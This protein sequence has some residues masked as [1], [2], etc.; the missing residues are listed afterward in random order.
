MIGLPHPGAGWT[1]QKITCAVMSGGRGTRFKAPDSSHKSMFTID[2][3]P[4]L[5]HVVDY[6]RAFTDDFVFVVK[7]GKEELIEYVRTIP[8]RA[9]FVEPAELKGIADGLTYAE[10]HVGERFILVL[11]DCF[12]RGRIAFPPAFQAGVVVQRTKN[13]AALRRN[14]AVHVDGDLVLRLEEKPTVL[15]SDLCGLG[16]YFLPRSV[17]GSIRR[18][19]PSART[20]QVEITDVLGTMVREGVP[21]RSLM[22]DGQYVNV[23]VPEDLDIVRGLLD[24]DQVRACP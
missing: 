4:L 22:L 8:I 23:T 3:Q 1:G 5:R 6:W 19:A 13:E 21:L 14:F 11:G 17:F 20:G 24:L 16:F 18:T 15:T 7:H 12:V 10:P 2:G 9:R